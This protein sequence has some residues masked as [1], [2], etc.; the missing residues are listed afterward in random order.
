MQGKFS[1]TF[2]EIESLNPLL[3]EKET[4]YERIIDSRSDEK[5]RSEND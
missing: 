3:E 5:I 4:G 2:L 1:C